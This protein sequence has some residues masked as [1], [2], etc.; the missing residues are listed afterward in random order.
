MSRRAATSPAELP[1]SALQLTGL[2]GRRVAPLP[3]SLWRPQLNAGTLG[4]L[5]VGAASQD[6]V[7]K[8][9]VRLGRALGILELLTGLAWL[10]GSCRYGWL[11]DDSLSNVAGTYSGFLALVAFLVPGALMLGRSPLRWLGQLPVLLV[12]GWVGLSVFARLVRLR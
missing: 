10:Y 11:A 3:G 9:W 12:V 6:R 7:A 8:R 2:V 4:R 1:N 5:E